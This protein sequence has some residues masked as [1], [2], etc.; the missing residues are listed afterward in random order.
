M[1]RKEAPQSQSHGLNDV[2]GILLGAAALLL[3]VALIS[4]DSQDMAADRVP[5]N[6]P[7]HN[8]GRPDSRGNPRQ[9]STY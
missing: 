5:P 4:H 6:N 1:A 9:L 8:L 7:A 3:M 2:I